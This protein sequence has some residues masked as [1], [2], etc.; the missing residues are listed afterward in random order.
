MITPKQIKTIHTL[1]QKHGQMDNKKEIIKNASA[2]GKESTKELSFDEAGKLISF[3]QSGNQQT[4]NQ[5][6]DGQQMIN[7]II[8][9]S[10]EMGWIKQVNK[11]DK[12]KGLVKANDYSMMHQELEK[13]CYKKPLKQYSMAE[14]TKLVTVVKKINFAYLHKPKNKT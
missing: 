9:A 3:L 10:H 2:S 12:V 6:A 14:L 1:L 7:Y 11:V 5:P 4:E 8:A 13:L